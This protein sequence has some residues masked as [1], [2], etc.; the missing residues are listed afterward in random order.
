[1]CKTVLIFPN[2]YII[3]KKNLQILVLGVLAHFDQK[4]QTRK[5]EKV[6]KDF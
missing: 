3:Q 2:I 4:N 1:M 5:I 6:H